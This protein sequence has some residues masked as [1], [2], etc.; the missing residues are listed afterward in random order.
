[1]L[2]G[3]NEKIQ[4]RFGQELEKNAPFVRQ[5]QSFIE[6]G[7]EAVDDLHLELASPEGSGEQNWNALRQMV[8]R[9]RPEFVAYVC[10][11]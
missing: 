7:I 8:S 2:N 11:V 4:D 3:G 9:Q 10:G 1:M 6:K 5:L